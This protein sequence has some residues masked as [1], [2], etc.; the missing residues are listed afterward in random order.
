MNGSLFQQIIDEGLPYLDTTTLAPRQWQVLHHLQDCRTQ[1]MGSYQWHCNY[2][3]QDTQW[4][5]SCR[6]RH[7][8]VCQ[9]KAREKWLQ[10]RQADVLPVTYHHLVFTLPHQFNGWATQHP[11]ILYKTLFKAVWQTLNDFATARH[12][13]DGKLGMLAVLHTWG[14][15]LSRHIHLHCLIP[16]GVLTNENKWCGSRKDSYLFPVKALS[17]KFRGKMLYYLAEQDSEGNLPYLAHEDVSQVL[18]Q[19]AQLKWNVYSKPAIGHTEAV[20]SY[21]ARYCNRVGI[22]ESRLTLTSQNNVLMRYK[23]YRTNELTHMEL[24]AVELIRR[25]L[26]HVLP[27]GFM[28]LRYYGFMANS[29]RRKSLNMIRS[30]LGETASEI[31]EIASKDTGEETGPECPNCHHVGMMLMGIKLPERLTKLNRTS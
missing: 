29:I 14:Q 31:S 3:E 28:R 25:F 1:A 22:S 5:C 27:K 6:D 9:G 24:S 10:K 11:D 15:T 16:S 19:T 21:L 23:D 18:K 12:H 30:S 7:C 4:Y 13:L 17:V 26:L 20:V 8:P 2:C